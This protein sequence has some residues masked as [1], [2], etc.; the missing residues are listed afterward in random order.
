MPEESVGRVDSATG[1]NVTPVE[2]P[3]YDKSA[4]PFRL[5][6]YETN[7]WTLAGSTATGV[8]LALVCK[9]EIGV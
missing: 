4:R 2:H 1:T 8:L 3:Y 5:P 9:W 6:I 7:R